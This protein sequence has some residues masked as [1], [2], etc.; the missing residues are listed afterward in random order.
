MLH[1]YDDKVL[2]VDGCKWA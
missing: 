2:V 1:A